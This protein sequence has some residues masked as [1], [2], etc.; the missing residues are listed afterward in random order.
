M[1][2]ETVERRPL[3]DRI[4]QCDGCGRRFPFRRAGL[5]EDGAILCSSCA[6]V[7]VLADAVDPG[8]DLAE[9]ILG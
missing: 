9:P 6:N 4:A 2:I 3:A 7:D 5:V 1:L 8:G